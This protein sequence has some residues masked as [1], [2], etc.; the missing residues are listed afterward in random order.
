MFKDFRVACG[1]LVTAAVLVGTGA[2]AKV[3][4]YLTGNAADVNPTLYGPALNLGGGGPDVD[5]AIQ[6]MIDQARGCTTCT[7][8]VDVVV[9]RATGTNGYNAPIAAMN[10]VDSVETLV[11]PSSNDANTLEVE[12]AVRNAEVVFFAGG[13]QCNY[14]SYYG[15]TRLQR[16]VDAV[17][18]RGGTVGGTSAGAMV[19]GEHVY[20]ACSGSVYSDEALAN[21]YNRYMTFSK[22]FFLWPVMDEVLVDTHFGQR[23]RMGRLMAFVARRIRDGYDTTVMGLGINEGTSVVVDRNG[24]ATVMGAGPAYFVQGTHAPERC[25]SGVALSYTDFRIWRVAAGGQFNLWTWPTSGY[26][27]RSVNNGVLSASPY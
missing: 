13:D 17:W 25:E 23:D 3:T 10:G 12:T 8:K 7:T 21:P 4:R 18:A 19:Q 26:Y 14:I 24:L 15:G 27:L 22:D 5:P 2:E 20:N 6:W 11:V 9:I 16:A 1:A